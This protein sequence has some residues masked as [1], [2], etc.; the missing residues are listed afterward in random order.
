MSPG[1][2]VDRR[3]LPTAC[4]H[5]LPRGPAP[6]DA[7]LLAEG[8]ESSAKIHR[9]RFLLGQTDPQPQQPAAAGRGYSEV[10]FHIQR[11]MHFHLRAELELSEYQQT[12]SF[13]RI[14]LLHAGKDS[15]VKKC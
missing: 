13:G 2:S 11:K 6:T 7:A 10:Q 8:E 15:L 1:D 3:G 9:C 12:V 14:S 4:T 5:G